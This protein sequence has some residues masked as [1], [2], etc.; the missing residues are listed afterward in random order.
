MVYRIVSVVKN[1]D[2][3]VKKIMNI[4]LKISLGVGFLSFWVLFY[5]DVIYSA[6][7]LFYIGIKLCNLSLSY[8]ISFFICAIVVDSI[9]KFEI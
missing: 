2:D 9:K 5:Y 8:A 6:T 3:K 1:L 7:D 4:G